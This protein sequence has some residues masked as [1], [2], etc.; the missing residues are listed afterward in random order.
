MPRTTGLIPRADL[1]K[2]FTDEGGDALLADAL[3]QVPPLDVR[4]PTTEAWFLPDGRKATYNVALAHTVNDLNAQRG[5]AFPQVNNEDVRLRL[6]AVTGRLRDR[7]LLQNWDPQAAQQAQRQV[8]AFHPVAGAS[9][10]SNPFDPP[11]HAR[12]VIPSIPSSLSWYA[13]IIASLPP[14]YRAS[15]STLPA[16]DQAAW[17]HQNWTWL[18]D[19]GYLEGFQSLGVAGRRHRRPLRHAV[20]Y[21][22]GR[23]RF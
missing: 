9:G 18:G 3:M 16:S 17:L 6:D 21:G 11:H 2:V 7:G 15:L 19:N 10:P 5:G 12:P 20:I 22:G 13:P 1:T 8:A 23:R 4:G 14:D